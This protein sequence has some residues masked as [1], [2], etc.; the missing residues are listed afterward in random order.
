MEILDIC[1]KFS[2]HRI[3]KNYVH[4]RERYASEV[5]QQRQISSLFIH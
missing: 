4:E 1:R 2:D 3:F 5:S